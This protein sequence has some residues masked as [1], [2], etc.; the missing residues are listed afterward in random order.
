[1]AREC[2]AG[3]APPLNI[4]ARSQL[5]AMKYSYW[6]NN[7]CI[8]IQFPSCLCCS[9]TANLRFCVL[10]PGHCNVCFANVVVNSLCRE[11]LCSPARYF[12][13]NP[14]IPWYCNSASWNLMNSCACPV[15]LLQLFGMNIA[16]P[17]ALSVERQCRWTWLESTVTVSIRPNHCGHGHGQS[18]ALPHA[19]VQCARTRW[20][21]WR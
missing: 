11:W 8:L 2:Q 15:R 10:N 3:L 4:E 1:M 5:Y 21:S 16:A 6:H 20:L 13:F 17:L 19:C 18:I 9:R 14:S 7:L 12:T